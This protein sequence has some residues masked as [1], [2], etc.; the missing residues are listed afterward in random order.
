MTLNG[1][2]VRQEQAIKVID[3]VRSYKLSKHVVR[4]TINGKRLG[5]EEFETSYI[6]DQD[7]VVF[8]SLVS[9]G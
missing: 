4:I 8:T 7:V 6:T 9:G 5:N 1:K 2:Y 3:F